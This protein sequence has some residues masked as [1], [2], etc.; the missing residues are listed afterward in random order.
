VRRW[1][2]R[3]AALLGLALTATGCALRQPDLPRAELE[4][5][6]AAPPS[7]FE[8]VLGLRVHLRDSGP[9]T[10]PAVLL[11]HG[12][13]ASLHAWEDWA[14]ELERDHRVLRIDLP[15]FGLTGPDATG[16]YTDAR[17]F[18]ILAA[19]LDRLG[20]ARTALIGSSMGGRIAWGFAASEPGRITRLVLLAPDG[21]ESPGLRYDQAP[22]VPLLLRLLPY[23]LPDVLFR[24]VIAG[25]FADPA[26]LTPELH[27]RY[28]E[29]MLA[30]GVRG[31][32][33]ARVGQHVLE[34]P[35]PR[36]ATLRMPVLL[37]WGREDRMVPVSNAA[38]YQAV[39]P[40]AQLLVLEGVGHV[41]M[42]EAPL[43]SLAPVAAFL[44][45]DLPQR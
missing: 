42:E 37:L 30:P 43:R 39:I 4:A 6:Y 2:A 26:T 44:A 41:P 33:V 29:M 8:D 17:A 24:P 14:R 16:D 27:A 38:D 11:L 20:I 19:L 31:A 40:Q 18:A 1:A 22:R 12:F 13:G 3:F 45:G 21:F 34:D 15:G 7:R 5:R 36:L 25:A 35:R 28:R 23:T 32:I 10:A 9:P